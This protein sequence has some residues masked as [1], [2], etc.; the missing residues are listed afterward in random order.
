METLE[1]ALIAFL[2]MAIIICATYLFFDYRSRKKHAAKMLKETK[3]RREATERIEEY[4]AEVI[5]IACGID[6]GAAKNEKLP[7]E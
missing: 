3:K 2:A 7:T 4:L 5:Y 6:N 1:I